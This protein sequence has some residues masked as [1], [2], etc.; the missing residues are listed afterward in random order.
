MKVVCFDLDDTLYKELDYL[1]E[2]YRV[3]ARKLWGDDWNQWY[4]QMFDWYLDGQNVFARLCEIRNDVTI[5]S[6]L[7]IYRYEVNKL[8]LPITVHLLLGELKAGG[9]KLGI[10]SDGRKVTQMNKIK[11]LG[12]DRY[13]DE[14]MIVISESFGSEKPC[15]ANYRYFMNKFPDCSDFTYVGDNPQKDFLAPNSLGWNTICLLDDGQNIHKQDFSLPKEY[16]PK[17]RINSLYEIV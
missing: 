3:I 5:G 10:I 8:V 15:E 17:V 9:I 11:A 7:N 1:H 16:L 2:G 6:L 12:L 4:L 13:F 14:D